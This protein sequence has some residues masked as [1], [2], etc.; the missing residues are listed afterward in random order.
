MLKSQTLP[1]PPVG[2]EVRPKEAAAR[3]GCSIGYVYALIEDGVLS[4]RKI[5]RADRFCLQLL[6]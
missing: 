4:S 6:L 2:G 1:G 3:I 5:T